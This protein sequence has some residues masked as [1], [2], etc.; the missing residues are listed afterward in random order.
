[1]E[2]GVGGVLSNRLFYFLS[3]SS[4]GV[5]GV[6]GSSGLSCGEGCN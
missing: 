4:D 2:E 6:V 1:M 3:F 5:D